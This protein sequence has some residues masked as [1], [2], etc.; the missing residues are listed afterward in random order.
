MN[1]LVAL[2]ALTELRQLI[3]ADSPRGAEISLQLRALQRRGLSRSD[4][5]V[6][7][8]RMRAHNDALGA[9]EQVEENAL[10]A[11]ELVEGVG[12]SA[13]AWD[14]AQTAATWVPR[15]I[16]I[17][18]LEAGAI[19]AL[20]ASDLLPSRV[21]IVDERL[22]RQL[23]D[24]CWHMLSQRQYEP[25]R[26]DF[27]RAPKK[28]LTTRP[29]ALMAPADRFVYE[30]LAQVVANASAEL[31]PHHVVWPR[32]RDNL[33]NYSQFA[34]APQD[35]NA[36]FVV[37]TDIANFYESIDHAYLSVVLA[38][39]LNIRGAFPIALEAFLDATMRSSSG[40]P[41]G[42]PG[43]D[44]LASAY[45]LDIDIELARQGWPVS[46]YADDILI[47]AGSFEEAR[48]RIRD[49]EAILRDRGLSLANDKTRIIRS[50]TYMANLDSGDEPESFRQRVRSEVASWFDENPAADFDGVL[51]ILDLPEEMQWDVLY[52]Q[53]VSWEDALTDVPE[54]VLPP[55]I[56][57]YE[58]I[59]EAEAS[60][61]AAGGYPDANDALSVGELRRCLIFM[62][63]DARDSVLSNS[64][65]VLDWH[66][67]LVRDFSR[68]LRA[69]LSIRSSEGH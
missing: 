38:R 57:A 19:F 50:T 8:E 59:Y 22:R 39:N 18:N 67:T 13:L 52:H 34:S 7:L 33:T 36:E 65:A 42:P 35:W 47:G 10:V 37:R 2:T 27:F 32:G 26:A 11:L 21:S 3:A 49:L 5:I 56:R 44:V 61:L 43:S 23:V 55:W 12:A 64:H 51:D 24:K 17:E 58:R 69:V 1:D 14:A 54:L 20:S 60:R 45:I 4:L 46:R 31:L 29:A 15:A 30:A 66:P 25:T 9:N 48:S 41:Q 68:Y 53:S 6:H 28:G 40:L 63:A 16:D 62:A